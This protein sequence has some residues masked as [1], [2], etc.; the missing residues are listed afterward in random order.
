MRPWLL[1]YEVVLPLAYRSES[2]YICNL[3]GKVQDSTGLIKIVIYLHADA[4]RSIDMLFDDLAR[5]N[6]DPSTTAG[7]VRGQAHLNPAVSL[8]GYFHHPQTAG[9]AAE[10]LMKLLCRSPP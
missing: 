9:A 7:S 8:Q 10:N 3:H 6:D 4:C 2:G 1:P 5:Y